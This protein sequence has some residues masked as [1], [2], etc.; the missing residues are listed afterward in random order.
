MFSEIF[1]DVRVTGK[2]FSEHS[3]EK[4]HRSCEKKKRTRKK[5]VQVMCA[6]KQAAAATCVQPRRKSARML[7]QPLASASMPSR[8]IWSHHDRF[9]SSSILQP[10]LQP[11]T[12]Q[13]QNIQAACIFVARHSAPRGKAWTTPEGLEG[14][15]ADGH[16]GSKIQL[17]EFGAELAEADAGAVRDLGAAI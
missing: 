13:Q 12:Q 8:V 6:W 4:Y 10:S 11:E 1:N 16:A 15:V 7:L 5:R 17:L 2:I 3:C 9:S 14:V